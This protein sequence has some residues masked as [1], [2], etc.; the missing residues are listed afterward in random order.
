[1]V[2]ALMRYVGICHPFKARKLDAPRC[3]KIIYV[4]V[5]VVCLACSLP[6]FFMYKTVSLNVGDDVI[7]IIDIGLLD[8]AS[9]IG[10]VF[11][12][13]KAVFG[14]LIPMIVLSFGN[15][16]LIKALRRSNRMRRHYRV[17]ANHSSGITL[18][19]VVIMMAFLILVFPS[20]IMDLFADNITK[21]Q[22]EAFLT[23]RAFA[24]VFQIINFAFNFILY[25][26]INVQFRGML[27]Q[28]LPCCHKYFPDVLAKF[29]RSVEPRGSRGS[30]GSIY[31]TSFTSSGSFRK[32]TGQ[33]T[34][35]QR[36]NGV[37]IFS[38]TDPLMV[39]QEVGGFS[40][41]LINILVKF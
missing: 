10:Q 18:T 33:R 16:S 23:A 37:A 24:N 30:R 11:I 39:Q 26:I 31:R 27:L 5:V 12:W 38:A 40:A 17:T 14:I 1:M 28:M 4:V 8:Q 29:R 21:S 2:M 25:C 35:S 7:H 34:T 13:W 36:E 20:E 3:S 32:K 22:T 19:L 41:E 15:F 9:T 6:S